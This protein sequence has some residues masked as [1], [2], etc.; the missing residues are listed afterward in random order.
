[1]VKSG[2]SKDHSIPGCPLVYFWHYKHYFGG[3]HGYAGI[4][5][6]L[7]QVILLYYLQNLFARSN[8]RG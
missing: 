1:M 3:A 4:L 5:Y 8:Y 7:L 6:Q 2:E